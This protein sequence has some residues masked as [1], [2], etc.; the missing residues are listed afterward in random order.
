VDKIFEARIPKGVYTL[1]KR[2]YKKKT[3]EV[4]PNDF[5]NL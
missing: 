4:L 5:D 1:L 3:F 2:V